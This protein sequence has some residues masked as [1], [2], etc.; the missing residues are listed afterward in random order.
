[1]KF[2]GYILLLF[3]A[4]SC[5]V[6]NQQNAQNTDDN[7]L[8]GRWELVEH[9]AL[10]N[11]EKSY[12]E[13][14][15]VLSFEQADKQMNVFGYDGCNNI[16]G[17]IKSPKKG[18]ITFDK[19][20][21]VSTMMAC[22]KVA[23]QDFMQ[24]VMAANSY[25]IDGDY[26]TLKSD[27]AELRFFKVSLNGKWTL[28]KLYNTRPKV[29]EL[30][31]YKTPFIRLDINTLDFTGHTACNAIQGKTLIH[32]NEMRFANIISTEMYC[33]NKGE[34]LFIDALQQINRYEL[35]GNKL[36]LYKDKKLLIEFEK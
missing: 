30:F 14:V 8:I 21:W 1:M 12:P 20:Q 18:E 5:K 28:S 2:F 13:G 23:D 24:A 3:L 10:K 6:N 31:P 36:L 35:S 25:A 4:I 32:A 29:A 11:L 22:D 34:K 16:R 17:Q 33:E 15:P 27:L 7:S 9:S 19:E 26:L